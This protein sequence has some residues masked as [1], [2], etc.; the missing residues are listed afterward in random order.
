M[1]FKFSMNIL[2]WFVQY[3]KFIA[4]KLDFNHVCV[5]IADEFCWW[6]LQ[7]AYYAQRDK[8]HQ[9]YRYFV[10]LLYRCGLSSLSN[11]IFQKVRLGGEKNIICLYLRFCIYTEG[12]SCAEALTISDSRHTYDKRVQVFSI[13]VLPQLIT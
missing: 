6:R 3:K 1:F 9:S 11:T 2:F 5:H 12:E 8:S 13:V 7:A 10:A 4:C